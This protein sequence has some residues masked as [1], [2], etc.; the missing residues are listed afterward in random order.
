MNIFFFF[1]KHFTATLRDDTKNMEFDPQK[2]N[3]KII[4]IVCCFTQFHQTRQNGCD[5]NNKSITHHN[6]ID[7]MV[8]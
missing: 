4:K 2:N 6:Q 3:L 7:E 5:M 1:L 8:K